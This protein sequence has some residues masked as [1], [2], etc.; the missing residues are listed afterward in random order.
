MYPG[1]ELRTMRY[2][3]AVAA[4]LHFSRAAEKV[5]VAQPSLSKQIRN[6]EQELGV[7]LFRRTRKKV[8]ITESGQV[9][10]ENAKQALL[11]A[12]RAASAARAANI[13][14]QGKLF[15]GVS[16][17][18]DLNLF[19]RLKN[20]FERRHGNVQF[21]FVSAFAREQAESVMRSDLHAALV[22][23]PIPHRGLAILGLTREHIEL[24]IARN[25][26]LA[27]RTTLL[28]KELIERPLV[29]LSNQA[30]L[31]HDKILAAIQ[32]WGY[33]AKKIFH[34]LTVMQALDFVEAGEAVGALRGQ[35]ARLVS[36]QVVSKAIPGLPSVD[37]AIVYRRQPRSPL[38]RNLLRIAREVFSEERACM[39]RARVDSNGLA[40]RAGSP[41][42]E[43]TP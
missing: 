9:F 11:Y 16:P 22:E 13:G 2:V 1:I 36:R 6:V 19:L 31:A 33:R 28:P 24:A 30:D 29:L 14:R 21:Q 35:F 3:V 25:D 39:D 5:H 34:V 38:V 42:T 27:S 17:S 10:I 37:T 41:H 32:N 26:F 15:L 20:A 7:E 8:E 43:F 40:H 12:E 4:E 23:L 18:V